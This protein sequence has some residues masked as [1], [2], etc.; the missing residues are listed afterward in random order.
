MTALDKNSN[1]YCIL[2]KHDDIDYSLGINSFLKKDNADNHPICI[3]RK[4]ELVCFFNIDYFRRLT[5]RMI[6]SP[7]PVTAAPR[8][9]TSP[10]P[11]TTALI[12]I[13]H[14]H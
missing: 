4:P 13:Y 8:M 7:L 5:T 6:I 1:V 3:E 2:V 14:T 12:D 11:V 10:L 9:R